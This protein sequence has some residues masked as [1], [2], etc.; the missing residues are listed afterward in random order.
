[1]RMCLEASRMLSSRRRGLTLIE[2]LA[3]LVIVGAIL[4]GVAAARAKLTSQWRLA[5]DKLDAVALVEPL[6]ADWRGMP[7][8]RGSGILGDGRMKWMTRTRRDTAAGTLAAEVVVLQVRRRRD[9]AVVLELEL[10][11]PWEAR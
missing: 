8:P 6:L 11:R 2:V 4:G 9:D 3:A 1:M 10:L 7:P 5:E